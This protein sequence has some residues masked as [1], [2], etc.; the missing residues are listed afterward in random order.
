MRKQTT[1]KLL[2]TT[3]VAGAS[4]TAFADGNPQ[5]Y[6]DMGTQGNPISETM[7][8]MFFE[9]INHAGDGGLYAELIK[10]RG[11]EEHVV[12]GGMTYEDGKV[13]APHSLNYYT[14]EYSDFY[15]DWDLES[16]KYDGWEI[17]SSGCTLDYDVVEMDD[18]LTDATPNALCLAISDASS[19][20]HVY[21]DN[22]GYWGIAV[23]S[24]A[25][26]KLR[27]FLKTSDYEGS[28]KVSIRNGNGASLASAEFDVTSDGE[29]N[30]YTA[31]LTP[32]STTDDGTVRLQFSETGTVYVDFVSLCPE[33]TFNGRENGLR[34]DVAEMLEG[35]HPGFLRW[36]GGCIVEGITLGNRVRWKETIGDV[37]DRP[38]EYSTWGYR[39]TYGFGYHE[40]LQFCEDLDMDGMFVANV[41]MSCSNRNGDYIDAD[42]T[43]SLESY[44]QDIRD[45]IEYAIGDPETNE[46]AAQ[47]KANGHEEAFPLK[48]VELGNENGTDRYIDRWDFFY[49]TLKEEYPEITFINTLSW[50]DDANFDAV[51]MY[52]VHWYVTPDEFYAD[53][54][55]FDTADRGDYTVY[56]GEYA[57]NNDVESGN[58][59]AALSEAVFAA[60]MERNGDLVTMASYAPLLTNTNAPNWSCNLIWFDNDQTMGRASYYVQKLYSDNCPDYNIKTRMQTDA[61]DAVTRG[62]I[63]V[64]T[65]S[66]Q[67]KFR[68]IKI[69][70]NDTEEVLWESDFDSRIDEWT[71]RSGSWSVDDDGYYTQSS[72]D[73][74]AIA[75]MRAYSAGNCTIELEAMKTGG[76]EGFFI[77]FG[78]DTLDMADYYRLNVGGWSN[79]LVG[80]EQVTD[81]GGGSLIGSQSSCTVASDTWIDLKFVM[82]E[83]DGLYLYMDGELIYT[84]DL[85]DVLPGRV[86]AYGG[87]D[88]E[89][90]EMVIK[91]VNAT[92]DEMPTDFTI[93]ANNIGET[94][95]VITL[96]A[97]DLED[98]NS[99]DNPTLIYPVETE[100]TGFASTFT[101][102]IEPRSLT[103]MRI[104]ADAGGVEA[105]DIPAYDYSDELIALTAYTQAKQVAYDNLSELIAFAEDCY[106][107]GAS[108]ASNLLSN[109]E[110]A[111]NVLND[112]DVTATRLETRYT[113]LENMLRRYFN[114]QMSDETDLTSL[115]ENADF[116]SMSTSGWLGSTPSLESYVGEFYNCT[117]DS[118]QN[119][120]GL[121]D[122]YYLL[123]VQAFYRDGSADNG[124][125]NALNNA[126]TLRAYLY[127]NDDEIY[128]RSLYSDGEDYGSANG[129]CD[130]RTE[131][132]AA[133]SADEDMYVNYLVA[134]VSNGKLKLGLRKTEAETYDWTC[135]NNFQ[136]Y[137]IV[138]E[139]DESGIRGVTINDNETTSKKKSTY[140]VQGQK[141]S[142]DRVNSRHGVYIINGKKVIK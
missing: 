38:G 62:C 124:Y 30:E 50:T 70:S 13:Y 136:L 35:L 54:T 29:W 116:A 108:K 141:L 107:E 121:D 40:F 14:Q 92:D 138:V 84:Y 58:M 61:Q 95:T 104:K 48:Y 135:F 139:D 26:Y 2:L 31:E 8:G 45:A 72:S 105:M 4:A 12:P 52:D 65:W 79:T 16:K 82:R 24:G 49:N 129:Y 91:V 103:I 106:V 80:I 42:D 5:V 67:A 7:Y 71:A 109:I 64:G 22:E 6:V 63:G 23:E 60:G 111:K 75:V 125:E 130:N 11:F 51:D 113:S 32:K 131:A 94:G 20:P 66:T 15:L 34:K 73:E 33:D 9:E 87:Y 120:T 69:M 93:N 55:L 47:R 68:N 85:P 118:Y 1:I 117:F 115:I 43:D 122:G 83:A 137:K 127:G 133:F 21:V 98:E 37:L 112:E 56:A 102:D 17:S 59:D 77:V 19:N 81:D 140:N 44:L 114:A 3:L 27:F 28:V 126:E 101:Y 39:S 110:S 86:Q 100:Y 78:A 134:Y 128:I 96:A 119:I 57:A 53:A 76:S 25:T 142:D 74:P 123:R 90:G 36:P 97:D 18:P 46:W 10:N 89:A 132:Y 99:L 88:E 41:G